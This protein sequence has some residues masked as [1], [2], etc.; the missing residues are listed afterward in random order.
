[1]RLYTSKALETQL[2]S[3]VSVDDNDYT[4]ITGGISKCSNYAHD[5]AIV[6]CVAVP[7]ELLADILE[8]ENWRQHVQARYDAPTKRGKQGQLQSLA[9]TPKVCLNLA[10]PDKNS[11][12]T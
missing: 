12:K 5:K 7:D 3:G 11:I 10:L 4:Q 6:G 1:M 2:L 9:P 8:L